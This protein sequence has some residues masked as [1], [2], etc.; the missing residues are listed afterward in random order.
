LKFYVLDTMGAFGN[1]DL[2]LL[3]DFVDGIGMHSWKLSKGE[4]LRPIYPQDARIFMSPESPGI[5]L[6]SLIGNTDR[7]LIVSPE[8]R[9]TL[10][11]HCRDET[12]YLPFTLYDHRKRARSRDYV[13][14]NPLGTFDCLDFKASQI[15]W[16]D[17]MPDK[18]IR[19]NRRVLSRDK[20]ER[21]PALF[22]IARDSSRYVVNEALAEELRERKFSNVVLAE[23]PV[24]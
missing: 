12:E 9:A 19:I 13:I 23:L 22:R 18:I 2:C 17:E 3:R 24:R 14:V 1:D 16:D 6:C 11:K 4:P 20:V 7:M 8:L 21:A 5:K 15:V 10:E